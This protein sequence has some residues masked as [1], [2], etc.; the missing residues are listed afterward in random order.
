MKI[1]KYW[2][3]EKQK[4][5]IDGNEQE[6]NC[7]GGSNISAEDARL[8]AREKAEKIQRKIAGEKHLF[9]RYEAEIREE[10]LR[11]IDDHS[12]ITRNRYGAQVLNTENMMILDIDKPKAAAGSG[13]AG[14]FKKK[15]MRPPKEQIF[16]MVRNLAA[17]KYKDLAFR[18]YET[19]QGAR[20]IVLGRDFDPRAGETKSMMDEFNCDPLYTMLCIKQGCYRARLTPKPY[21]MKLRG[22]K[23]RYPREVDETE[24][25]RWLSEYEH[26]S[27]DFSVCKLV[28][29]VGS[30]REVNDVV[31]LHDD[32]TGVGYPLRLA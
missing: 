10:L 14:L 21:R 13:L 5:L 7:Y 11:I 30:S 1:Y 15:D 17:A 3:I 24:F 6:I 32:I 28:E 4:I 22:Y 12:A 25:Q 18:L 23:V 16:E 19:Y 26:V 9:D 20:V 31:R 8:R 29:Q 2:V 27:R